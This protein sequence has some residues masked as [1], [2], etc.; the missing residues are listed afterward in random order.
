MSQFAYDSA[1][2]KVSCVSEG[3]S[4]ILMRFRNV[5]RRTRR[6][7][8]PHFSAC[9]FFWGGVGGWAGIYSCGLA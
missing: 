3:V 5:C 7:R 4:S 1:S 2:T 8:L 9:V 6:M